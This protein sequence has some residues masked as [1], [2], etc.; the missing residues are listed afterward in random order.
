MVVKLSANRQNGF[1]PDDPMSTIDVERVISATM[2]H[3]C[4]IGEQLEMS[5]V[6][7]TMLDVRIGNSSEIGELGSCLI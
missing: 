2:P 1:V 6:A 5:G 3:Q 4:L 7:F